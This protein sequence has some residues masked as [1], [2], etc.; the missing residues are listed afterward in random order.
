MKFLDQNNQICQVS[1]G[2]N[3]AHL[4]KSHFTKN[5]PASLN[6]C[7]FSKT[8]HI[9][10]PFDLAHRALMTLSVKVKVQGRVLF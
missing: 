3:F 9:L 5:R 1:E 6:I 8:Q 7:I 4:I 2:S 10:N